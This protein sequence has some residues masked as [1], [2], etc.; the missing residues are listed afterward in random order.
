METFKIGQKVVQGAEESHS[1]ESQ[2]SYFSE[3]ALSSSVAHYPSFKA[4]CPYLH[5]SLLV[6]SQLY[7]AKT[8]N[9]EIIFM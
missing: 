6:L 2:G 9:K 5:Q 3:L 7:Y 1:G 4:L 8:T